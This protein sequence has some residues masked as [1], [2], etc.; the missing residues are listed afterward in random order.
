M[1]LQDFAD[2]SVFQEDL[3]AVLKKTMANPRYS[4]SADNELQKALRKYD[5]VQ[6]ALLD[7]LPLNSLFRIYNG[8]VFKKMEKK[9]TRYRCLR[10]DNHQTYSVSGHIP[11]F[12]VK[13]PDPLFPGSE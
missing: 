12:P 8:I 9:R 3:L 10:M 6:H 5:K 13:D 11:V 4:T 7:D 2:P 1:L